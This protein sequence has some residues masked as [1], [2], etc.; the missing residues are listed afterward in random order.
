MGKLRISRVDRK[1]EA[2]GIDIHHPTAKF[3]PTIE[4]VYQRKVLDT[5]HIALLTGDAGIIDAKTKKRR[6]VA[7]TNRLRK[8]LDNGYL[9]RWEAQRPDRFNPSNNKHLFHFIGKHAVP[10]LEAS[11][12][13][14]IAKSDYERVKSRADAWHDW[15]ISELYVRFTIDA[16]QRAVTYLACKDFIQ[17]AVSPAIREKFPF[18]QTRWRLAGFTLEK[19]GDKEKRLVP[20]DVFALVTDKTHLLLLEGDRDTEDNEHQNPDQAAL[21]RKWEGYIKIFREGVHTKAYGTDNVRVLV[22]TSS[23]RRIANNIYII[24]EKLGFVEPLFYFSTF[25]NIQDTS[26]ILDLRWKVN[27]GEYRITP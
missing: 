23:Q 9:V 19:T 15:W 5:R 20:D 27:T 3:L 14:A 18:T 2:K 4:L 13:Y 7:T 6:Y 25:G 12:P 22:V 21:K 26:N 24:R 8:L 10:V 1:P 16:G 17:G 11:F